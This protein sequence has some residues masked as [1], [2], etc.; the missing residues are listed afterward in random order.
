MKDFKILLVEDDPINALVVTKTFKEYSF[1][2]ANSGQSALEK[3]YE[4]DFRLILMDINLGEPALDG[5]GVMKKIRENS[6]FAHIPIFA[7]TSY[8]MQGDREKFLK[9]GFN[10]YIS[11]PIG[12]ENLGAI[13]E[14]LRQRMDASEG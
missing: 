12:R 6:K 7:V 9:E 2:V 10:G 1:T 11:K 3:V 8:G 14:G 5:I 13:I 4:E